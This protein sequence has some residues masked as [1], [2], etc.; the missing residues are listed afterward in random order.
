MPERGK[1]LSRRAFLTI[2]V[3]TLAFV[4]GVVVGFY[5]KNPEVVR[6]TVND[7]LVALEKEAEVESSVPETPKCASPV[8]CYNICNASRTWQELI[9][10]NN[11]FGLDKPGIMSCVCN[12]GRGQ[13]PMKVL[14]TEF[15][16][17]DQTNQPPDPECVC[18]RVR[19]SE[20]A[21]E[22]CKCACPERE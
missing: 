16:I 10:R 17:G 15:K 6:A 9:N 11:T 13:Y 5:A 3:A 19:G 20:Q 12:C 8:N 18:Q 1:V 14:E 7:F 2:I 22:V 21:G 4:T